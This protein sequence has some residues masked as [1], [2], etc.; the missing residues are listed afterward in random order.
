MTRPSPTRRRYNIVSSGFRSVTKGM[1]IRMAETD[2]TEQV[3]DRTQTASTGEDRTPQG[4][5]S[6]MLAN[7]RRTRRA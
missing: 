4:P 1:L 6:R 3:D 7:P 5:V 2:R